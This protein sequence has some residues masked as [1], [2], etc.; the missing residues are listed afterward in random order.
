MK[1]LP[2]YL[3]M[4][5]CTL[6][7]RPH[8]RPP[9]SLIIWSHWGTG[10]YGCGQSYVRPV[11]SYESQRSWSA[12]VRVGRGGLKSLFPPASKAVSS[13]F[14]LLQGM[15]RHQFPGANTLLDVFS[16]GRAAR[17]PVQAHVGWSFPRKPSA[18]SWAW[19]SSGD[20]R[21]RSELPGKGMPELS[22]I[23]D[24]QLP[25]SCVEGLSAA[26]AIWKWDCCKIHSCPIS[27]LKVDISHILKVLRSHSLIFPQVKNIF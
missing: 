21:L 9:T 6:R 10:Q 16:T 19:R 20:S 1:I 4:L 25:F 23:W 8:W 3:F 18:G 22:Q 2:K 15:A 14:F 26:V 5:I 7:V 13:C 11:L 27:S 24:M 17:A 12:W